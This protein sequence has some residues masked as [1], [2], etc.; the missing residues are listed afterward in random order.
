M[1]PIRLSRLTLC[2]SNSRRL[3]NFPTAKAISVSLAIVV[4][5]SESGGIEYTDP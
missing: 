4:V 1:S 2:R 3:L 5:P